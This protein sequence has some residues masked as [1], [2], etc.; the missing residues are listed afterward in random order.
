V[1]STN[2]GISAIVDPVG[3]LE[4]RTGQWTQETLVGEVPMMT[5][6]TFFSHAGNWL[7]WTTTAF[8]LML[9]GLS[10]KPMKK[11][12]KKRLRKAQRR[13]KNR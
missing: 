9:I 11:T 5:G 3:R 12:E 10:F 6:R 4:K 2:T 1:R 7:G 8:V 13:A